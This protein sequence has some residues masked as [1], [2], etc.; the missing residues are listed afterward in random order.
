MGKS[1]LHG[2]REVWLTLQG[3]ERASA[4]SETLQTLEVQASSHEAV[5]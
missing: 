5:A 4:A 3:Q 2:P 1:S